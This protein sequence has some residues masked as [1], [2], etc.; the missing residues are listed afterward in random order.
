MRANKILAK[1]GEGQKAYGCSLNFSSATVIELLGQVD[2]DYVFLDGEHGPFTPETIEEMCRAADL[3]GLTPIARVPDIS[4]P[5]ILRFLDRGVMGIQG[6]HISTGEQAQALSDACRFA[7]RGKRSFGYGLRSVPPAISAPEFM[8]Q[9]DSQVLVIA[10]IEDVEAMD[11]LSDLL[12]VDGID[13]FTIGAFDLSQSMGVPGESDHP[14]VRDAVAQVEK[15]VRAAGR[16]MVSDVMTATS[17][18]GMLLEGTR[19]FLRKNKSA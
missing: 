2:L 6:P 18:T 1:M 9:I 5:T 8:A 4:A 11:N 16:R 7:P 19:D 17:A 10:M 15:R 12:R 14:T 3:A 13:L